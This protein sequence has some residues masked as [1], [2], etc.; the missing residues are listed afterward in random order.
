MEVRYALLT[1]LSE[2]SSF[3]IKSET[4][5]QGAKCDRGKARKQR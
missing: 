2:H 3:W 5:V 4:A 1:E